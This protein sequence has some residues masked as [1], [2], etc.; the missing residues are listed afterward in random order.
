L[1]V[2]WNLD[3]DVF[4]VF[5][6]NLG[7]SLYFAG[8]IILLLYVV[9]IFFIFHV[10]LGLFIFLSYSVLLWDSDDL[11]RALELDVLLDWRCASASGLAAATS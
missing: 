2:H 6:G 5:F 1:H 8:D 10:V 4:V 9:S 7:D 11:D 3:F